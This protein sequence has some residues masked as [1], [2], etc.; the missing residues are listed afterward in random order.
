MPAPIPLSEDENG[1]IKAVPHQQREGVVTKRTLCQTCDQQCAVVTESIDGQVV[2][3]RSSDNP[4]FRDHICMKAIA[5]PQ[6]FSHP[7][8]ILYPLKRVGE[9][10]SGKWERVSW[11]E[12]MSDI[13]T[14][15]NAIIETYG[16][17]A[18]A[19]STSQW[20]TAT[21]HG[22]GR[23]IMNHVG[24]PNWTSGVAYCAGNT[25][26][27]NRM[28]YGWFP[29]GDFNNTKCILL[30]GHSPNR[31][32]WTM[33]YQ[34]LRFAIQRGAKVIVMD[35]RKSHWAEMADIW[36]PLKA[37]SDTAMMF[38]FLKVIIDE[39]LYDKAF[40]KNWTIGFDDLKKRVDEYPLDR[41]ARLTGCDP[42]MIAKAAR[43]YA[44]E[45]PSVIPWT[46]IT[47]MQRNSTSGIRLQSIL[48]A[49]CGHID[50]RG[51]EIFNG[52]ITD[53][54]IEADIEMHEVLPHAQKMK[55]LGADTHPAFTY[56]G[57]AAFTEPLKRIW[58]R[59]YVNQ[60]TGCYM[61][62]P[63]EMFR[64][65]CGDGPY[66]VKAFFAL[67]NNTILSYANGQRIIDGMMNQELVVVQEHAMTPTAQLA[68]YVLPGDSWHERPW[69]SD[70]FSWGGFLRGS[71][72]S[73]EPMGEAKS[74]WEFWKLVANAI[75]RPELVPWDNIYDFYDD[76][77]KGMGM[78]FKE[79]VAKTDVYFE[80][81]QFRKYEAKGFAT[82]SG[83]VE[84]RSSVLEDLGF[85]G[86]PYF[87]ED[88]ELT[89]EYPLKMFTGVREDPYFQTAGR[90]VPDMRKRCPE[91]RI[92][93]NQKTADEW[94]VQADEWVELANEL[95]TLR[96]QVEINPSMPD[97]LVRVPHGW[98]KPEMEIGHGKLSGAMLHADSLMC[99][100]DPEYMDI[101][102]GIPHLKGIPCRINKITTDAT[103]KEGQ[104]D[105]AEVH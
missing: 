104:A 46:P 85:D 38:G 59:A 11:E 13:G 29:L 19:V 40:V 36:L 37:G 56:R 34:M 7:D 77:L 47:D 65:M 26:A 74:T 83:K 39:G 54:V 4:L 12:A 87:R 33:I 86:L 20:N 88:P 14:R 67:G 30:M 23:R 71:E 51:G 72:Q 105:V 18:W 57:Q 97:D 94:D 62:N 52:P 96:M 99:R 10:G 90:Q 53:F 35:P 2:R 25:A 73:Q 70:A 60:N 84:L 78:T 76:R 8:R 79:F 28:T 58:G 15:L 5:S 1:H 43:M 80:P 50:V 6:T 68:D 64:A 32:S 21:D 92:F 3:V 81:A 101:E 16:P 49:I 102:Q 42:E 61:A 48:R 63:T 22:L 41:V 93:V 45:G 100:D 103:K 98:W 69:L 55:Q 91:P 24:T 9:R 82:P 66:P 17:E 75:G 89:E 95:A 27:I 31:H 44:T